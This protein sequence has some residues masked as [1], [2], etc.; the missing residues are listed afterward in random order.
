[1]AIASRTPSRSRS[2]EATSPRNTKSFDKTANFLST[3]SKRQFMHRLDGD[4]KNAQSLRR[5]RVHRLQN[6]LTLHSIQRLECAIL[7]VLSAVA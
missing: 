5:H 3:S 6:L 7:T 4:S 2:I 1:M